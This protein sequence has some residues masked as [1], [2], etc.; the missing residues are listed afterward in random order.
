MQSRERP[1]ILHFAIPFPTFLVFMFTMKGDEA[2]NTLEEIIC[3]YTWGHGKR[4]YFWGGEGGETN[5]IV[6]RAP[7]MG[8]FSFSFCF[9]KVRYRRWENE[10]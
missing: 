1:C 2:V 9:H 7:S 3:F 6:E 5:K 4:V 10:K 8:S